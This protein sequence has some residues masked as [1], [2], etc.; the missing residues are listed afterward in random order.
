MGY[1]IGDRLGGGGMGE[2]FRAA[3]D[4][5]KVAAI[6][7]LRAEHAE[8]TDFRE[9]FDR[10]AKSLG[11]L[12]HPN[13]VSLFN[14]GQLPDGNLVLIMELIDGETLGRVMTYYQ[15]LGARDALYFGHHIARPL[16]YAHS[17]GVIHRDL[18]PENVMVVRDTSEVKIVDFGIAKL[19]G[20]V[21]TTGRLPPVATA[22]YASLE[23]LRSRPV[24]PK[25]DVYSLGVILYQMLSGRHP[26][27]TEDGLDQQLLAS[28]QVNADIPPLDAEVVDLP[29]ST[30]DLILQML[31]PEA[32]KRP[33]MDEVEV[34][35]RD[36]R[37]GIP[38]NEFTTRRGLIPQ[39]AGDAEGSGWVGRIPRPTTPSKIRMMEFEVE[40]T[41]AL[42]PHDTT[43]AS[44]ITQQ[45][46][47]PTG[48]EEEEIFVPA[49]GATEPTPPALAVT[50]RQPPSL[51]ITEKQTPSPVAIAAPPPPTPDVT[52]VHAALPPGFVQPQAR[53]TA[54]TERA[55]LRARRTVRMYAFNPGATLGGLA[56]ATLGGLE[57]SPPA[58]D[59]APEQS[60]RTSSAP[61]IAATP[62]SAPS[63]AAAPRPAYT[64]P[65]PLVIAPRAQGIG[66]PVAV[67][68]RAPVEPVESAS[69]DAPPRY[70][71]T[72]QGHGPPVGRSS[73][74]PAATEHATAPSSKARGA[75]VGY[76]PPVTV[77]SEPL[78]PASARVDVRPP[79]PQDSAAASSGF[80][81]WTPAPETPKP[82]GVLA[83][84]TQKIGAEAEATAPL[85]VA[86][87]A[88]GAPG[89]KAQRQ[90]PT[91]EP[92]VA[93]APR[94]SLA[95]VA[96]TPRGAAAILIGLVVALGI[97]GVVFRRT[98]PSSAAALPS[99][100]PSEIPAPIA[101]TA[102]PPTTTAPPA[103]SSAATVP[104]AP[105]PAN[106][107]APMPSH[108]P[109]RPAKPKSTGLVPLVE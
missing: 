102:P 20:T 74:P 12:R 95:A 41:S 47:I 91:P 51:A 80:T 109:S 58:N 6:K 26:F 18:K 33:C 8:R 49:L 86:S 29:K 35:L 96:R 36:Q 21:G 94:S 13:V 3:H 97:G 77:V 107:P 60:A 76:A 84:R 25:S 56:G 39:G 31:D 40:P 23:Q 85:P 57:V 78:I 73:R 68:P 79:S 108:L 61:S 34:A 5:G 11:L 45:D 10:E 65:P 4:T 98:E 69:P 53:P 43:D 46:L 63:I 44:D 59:S 71:R 50:E 16:A 99:P 72:V 9:R 55:D 83:L 7:V 81:R 42:E 32:A 92:T 67:A 100:N 64:P 2:V 28:Y 30:S 93:E 14:L 87:G 106:K 52:P 89:P 70:V 22:L 37:A 103:A 15:R 66:A 104:P 105:S 48:V 88:S 54:E 24:T 38:I 1:L 62:S 27:E 19:L 90:T 75:V 82:Q 17:Q 101:S